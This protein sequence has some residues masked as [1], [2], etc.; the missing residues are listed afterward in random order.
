MIDDTQISPMPVDVAFITVNYNTLTLLEELAA[1]FRSTP[2]PFTHLLV[3]VD[4]ASS[5][6]SHE[7]LAEQADIVYIPAGENLGYGR[8]INRGIQATDSRYVC[9]LNTDV[10]LSGKT[11]ANLWEFMEKTPDAGVVAPRITNR[12]GSTQGFIFHKST[13]SN[14]FHLVNKVRTSLLKMKLA[15]AALPM[16]V[17]GV[18]GAFFLARRSLAPDGRLFDEDFFF[19]FEDTDLAHRLFEAGVN[20][21]ALPSCSIIHLGGSST[22]LEGARLFFRSKNLYLKKHYGRVFADLIKTIDM[23]RL[24][25]KFFKYSLLA[26]VFSSGH[27]AEKKAYYSSMRFASDF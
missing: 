17:H 1:F 5:D 24:R 19:Y 20:C 21:Y 9:V 10:V 25:M 27:I 16:R 18:L 15:R 23:F 14:I 12:D 3:V 4:N 13:L 6:G 2:L 22:S 11:L 8:A 26:S 7:Y